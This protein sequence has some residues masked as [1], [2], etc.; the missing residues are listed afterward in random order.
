MH[1]DFDAVNRDHGDVESVFAEQL[2]VGFDVDL[3]ERE[4]ITASRVLDRRFRLITEMT[5]RSRI[6]DDVALKRYFLHDY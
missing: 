2:R 6:D 5:A 4:S 3:F 1:E